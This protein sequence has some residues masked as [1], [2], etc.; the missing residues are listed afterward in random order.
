MARPETLSTEAAE[1]RCS[2]LLGWRIEDGKLRRKFSFA[3]FPTAFA[4]MTRV[5]FV[6]EAMNHHPNWAN[7]WAHVDVTLWTHDAGGLTEL[8]FRLAE[9]MSA[10]ASE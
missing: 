1:A 7:V 10:A 8:D 2:E 9:A 3:D 6:A 5:A 4:F